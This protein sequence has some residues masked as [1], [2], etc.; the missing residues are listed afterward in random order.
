MDVGSVVWRERGQTLPA[1]QGV[2]HARDGVS[3]NGAL[4]RSDNS[5]TPLGPRSRGPSKNLCRDASPSSRLRG[6]VAKGACDGALCEAESDDRTSARIATSIPL[7]DEA[8]W[9]RSSARES[10]FDERVTSDSALTS[11]LAADVSGTAVLSCIV[12]DSATYGGFCG[13]LCVTGCEAGSCAG[14]PC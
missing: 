9:S 14:P 7:K 10:P 1:T 6:P 12:E 5:S 2:T 13:A 8:I 3:R 4:R 11:S